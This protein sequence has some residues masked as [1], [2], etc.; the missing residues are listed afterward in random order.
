MTKMFGISRKSPAKTDRHSLDIHKGI[1]I[2]AS[3]CGERKYI[4]RWLNDFTNL[5][6]HYV[7]IWHHH[8]SFSHQAEWCWSLAFMPLCPNYHCCGHQGHTTDIVCQIYHSK[9][10]CF[11]GCKYFRYFHISTVYSPSSPLSIESISMSLAPILVEI[12]WLGVL[13]SGDA[14][15]HMS[16]NK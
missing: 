8:L 13:F 11:L 9:E 10:K 5:V 6:G 12:P 7:L 4:H 2:A 1:S 3:L 16:L 15:W 14:C